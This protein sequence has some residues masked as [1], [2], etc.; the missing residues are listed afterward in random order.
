MYIIVYE[1]VC[2]YEYVIIK[3]VIPQN[4][5][6]GCCYIII[7]FLK[8]QQLTSMT[9]LATSSYTHSCDGGF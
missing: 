6:G 1:L 5:I 9:D 8:Q 7:E 2:L 3:H 4:P